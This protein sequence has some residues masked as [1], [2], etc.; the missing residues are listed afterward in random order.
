MLVSFFSLWDVSILFVDQNKIC[1]STLPQSS[2][3]RNVQFDGNHWYL[4]E[5]TEWKFWFASKMLV[6]WLKLCYCGYG[7]FSKAFNSKINQRQSMQPTQ[8]WRF[9]RCKESRY[10]WFY[11]LN[12]SSVQGFACWRFSILKIAYLDQVLKKWKLQ[13]LLSW[14]KLRDVTSSFFWFLMKKNLQDKKSWRFLQ[15][16]FD[17]T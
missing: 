6:N 16:F 14:P 12:I 13:D 7:S 10:C 5:N 3:L 1:R 17:F 8:Y 2:S 4:D 11:F 15:D 9:K